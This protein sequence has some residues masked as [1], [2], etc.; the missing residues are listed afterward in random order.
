[1]MEILGFYCQ[2]KL[3]LNP[4]SE[5]YQCEALVKCFNLSGPDFLSKMYILRAAS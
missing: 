4:S 5:T 2:T 3:A 1:M